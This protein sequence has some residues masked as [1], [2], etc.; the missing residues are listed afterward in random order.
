MGADVY[1]QSF[2]DLPTIRPYA[3]QRHQTRQLLPRPRSACSGAGARQAAPGHVHRT[4]NPLHRI[5]RCS[6]TRRTRPWPGSAS[7]S[8]SH[9][10]PMARC[11]STTTTRHSVRPASRRRCRWIG[12][13]SPGCTPGQ[14]RQKG[15][16]GAYSFSGGPARR[17]RQRHQCAGQAAEVTVW[18]E[19]RR[20]ASRSRRRRHR[21]AGGAQRLPPASATR[22]PACGSGPTQSTSK[23]PAAAPGARPTCCAARRC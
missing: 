15:A 13:S 8:R 2:N 14:V 7:A 5:R 11:Q 18:R 20:R 12:S 1:I 10:I 6:T 19:G 9:P 3:Q 23:A 16:G 17:G 22:A 4:D 21:A